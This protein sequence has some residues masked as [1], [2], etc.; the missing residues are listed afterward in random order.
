MPAI[1]GPGEGS[2]APV[3]EQHFGLGAREVVGP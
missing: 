2:H 3:L 1:R